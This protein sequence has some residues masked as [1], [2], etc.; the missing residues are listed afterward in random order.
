[1]NIKHY[2]IGIELLRMIL[3]FL[4]VVYH[5]HTRVKQDFIFNFSLYYIGFYT[6]TFFLISFYFSF[7]SLSSKIIFITVERLQRIIIPYLLWPIIIF[8]ESNI[9]NYINSHQVKYSIRHLII[10]LVV[11]RKINDVFW[12]QSNLIFISL[13][14]FFQKKYLCFYFL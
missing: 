6:S 12:F 1:M 11:G 5:L 3:S 8:M 14:I 7:K 9:Y 10:Q 4:I 2:N 13:I